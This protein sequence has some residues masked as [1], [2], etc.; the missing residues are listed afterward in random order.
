M[1]TNLTDEYNPLLKLACKALKYFL[2]TLLGFAIAYVVSTVF[3]AV[4]VVRMLLFPTLWQWF[5]R[6]AVFLLFLLAVAIIVES[7]R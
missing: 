5:V 6:I 7:S 1:K 4:P 3:G 2:L